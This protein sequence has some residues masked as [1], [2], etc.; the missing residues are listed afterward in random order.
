MATIPSGQMRHKVRVEENTPSQ[1][2]V[3]EFVN[4]WKH[5][6]SVFAQIRSVSGTEIDLND[7][8]FANST[9]IITT[10][11]TPGITEE[12][13]LLWNPTPGSTSTL[14][15]EYA[16]NVDE[17]NHTLILLARKQT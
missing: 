6:V 5:K 1:N 12:M 9:H 11:W 7:Q 8:R 16:E 17:Q 14:H 15:I 13:R 3:G 10:H 2:S 4:S